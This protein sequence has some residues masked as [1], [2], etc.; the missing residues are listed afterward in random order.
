MTPKGRSSCRT[1]GGRF[2]S[3]RWRVSSSSRRKSLWQSGSVGWRI[4]RGLGKVDE[5]FY[6]ERRWSEGRD[7]EKCGRMNILWKG[8]VVVV[9]TV[10]L[11]VLDDQAEEE[12]GREVI[13][14]VQS[15]FVLGLVEAILISSLGRL[16]MLRRRRLMSR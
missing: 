15:S 7:F 6:R 16:G 2:R 5:M 1:S 12:D 11:R 10:M 4:R 13:E 14:T 8:E 3:R 9:V